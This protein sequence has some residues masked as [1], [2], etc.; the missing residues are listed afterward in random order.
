MSPAPSH[1]R[2]LAI[3]SAA[4]LGLAA[5]KGAAALATSSLALA[6]SALDSALDAVLSLGNW[7]GAR[8]AAKPP[9]DDHRFGHG[10]AEALFALA[11]AVI[12]GGMVLALAAGGVIR[13]RSGVGPKAPLAAALAA[14]VSLGGT[15]AIIVYLRRSQRRKRDSLILAT[16]LAHYSLDFASG[17]AV[18]V[19]LLLVRWTGLAEIDAVLSIIVA[20]AVLSGLRRIVVRALADLTDAALPADVESIIDAVIA[21]HPEA[22]GYHELRTR[23]AGPQQFVALHLELPAELPFVEAHRITEEVRDEIE[24]AVPGAQVFIHGDP[25]EIEEAGHRRRGAEIR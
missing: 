13:L 8:L 17:A 16:D 15:L 2:S 22:V 10:K 19:G 20:A 23:R 9:D 21:R 4:S 7:Y 3:A 1:G 25:H 14:L 6:A 11:Q 12:L 24:A 5:A 18:L